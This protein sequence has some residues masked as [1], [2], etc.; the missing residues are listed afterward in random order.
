MRTLV[1]LHSSAAAGPPEHVLPWLV[2]LAERGPLVTVV[3]GPGTSADLYATIGETLLL[4]YERLTFPRRPGE[5]V[6]HTARFAA[7]VRAFRRVLRDVRPDLVLVVT[8]AVPAALLAAR[9]SGVP[10]LVYVGE[11]LD[12]GFEP[13][14]V[15]SLG[16]TAVLRLTSTADGIIGCSHAVTRQFAA[17][18]ARV[19]RTIYPG[20]GDDYGGGDGAGF[21]SLRGLTDA[22][23]LLAVVGNVTP[24]R[25]QDVVLRALPALRRQL[26]SAHCV[27]AGVPH[28]HARDLAYRDELAA[29]A[30]DLGVA[31]AVTCAG[32]VRP[33]ADL[34]AAA[35]VVVN[36]A[37]FNEPFGRVAVEALRAGCPVVA[38]DIGAI[39][40]VVRDGQEAL[41]VAPG[42]PDA[43]VSAVVRLHRDRALRSELVRNGRARAD[44]LFDE[45]TGVA[46]FAAVVDGVME[47]RRAAQIPAEAPAR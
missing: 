21:R 45:S 16:A 47:A 43:I 30:R 34:F 2:P 40:E 33:I 27:F 26:P 36:P 38:S 14:R 41:L 29:L 1:I 37:R 46:A 32:L 11:I 7:D 42:D 22:D 9:R 35:D 13:S 15:R 44:A 6:A 19:V 5:V 10:T 25:G 39:P 4:R 24:A 12:K 31:D 17:S 28:Q 23:P 18:R 8:A 20:V 3:P